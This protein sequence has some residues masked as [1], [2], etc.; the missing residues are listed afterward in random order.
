LF[1]AVETAEAYLRDHATRDRRVLLVVTDGIDNASMATLSGIQKNAEQQDAAIYAIGLFGK[2][3]PGRSARGRHELDQ[4]TSRNGGVAY[5]PAGIDDIGHV[6]L[7]I[8]SQ[9][10]NQ[11]TIAYAPVNQALDGSYRTIK[12]AVKGP[13]DYIVHTRSGYRAM[14]PTK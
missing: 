5:F 2:D 13:D 7:D 1:D 6:V 10:R 4:L 11:Y 3:D 12:V 14:G 9:I 8:A